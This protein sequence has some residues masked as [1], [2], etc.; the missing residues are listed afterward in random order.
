MISN[1][2]EANNT[3]HAR[4]QVMRAYMRTYEQFAPIY[5]CRFEKLLPIASK[6]RAY[7]LLDWGFLGIN[8]AGLYRPIRH[9]WLSR[10]RKDDL[11]PTA[12]MGSTQNS[13]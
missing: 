13:N 8:G 1:K 4:L 10:R 5:V 9:G 3:L 2:I 12:K 6:R 7:W 11:M